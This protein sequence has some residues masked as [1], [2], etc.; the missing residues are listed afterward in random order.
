MTSGTPAVSLAGAEL[1]PPRHVCAFF[2]S[3]EE[4]Y[5]V[6]APFIKTGLECG[7]GAVHIVDAG[8]SEDHRSRLDAAGIDTSAMLRSGQLELRASLDAYLADGR[9]DADRMLQ[10]FE[11]LAAGNA[12]RGFPS[13]R[14]ICRMEWAAAA[15]TFVDQVIEFEARV[16]ELWRRR[17]DVVIC[18]YPLAR[19]GGDAVID[20][21]RTH[22]LTIIGGVL[23]RNPFFVPPEQFVR[24]YR[25][26]RQKGVPLRAE[27]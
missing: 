21:L 7:H 19:F 20:I 12:S 24:E 14:I 9:F 3:D 27:V 1:E 13:S 22:P 5:R 17:D 10:F 11:A 16:N 15:Q 26:R 6:L 2:N 4:E 23:Q 8:Q 25:E 18:T